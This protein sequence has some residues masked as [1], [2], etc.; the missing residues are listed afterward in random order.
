MFGP[1]RRFPLRGLA[2]V[3]IG[4]L[5][6]G[7]L[8]GGSPASGAAAGFGLLFALPLLMFKMFFLFFIFGS[9]FRFA[10]GGRGWDRGAY[11]RNSGRSTEQPRDVEAE[12]DR[13]SWEESL[14]QARE[15]VQRLDTSVFPPRGPFS[16]PNDQP[17]KPSGTSSVQDA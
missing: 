4:F 1:F 3:A 6:A 8:A 16:S 13:R 11:D 10:G 14:R 17:E 5:L 7:A 9:F 15:E 2:L 12:Q